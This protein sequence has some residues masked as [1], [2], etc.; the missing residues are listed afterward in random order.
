[1]T[2]PTKSQETVA[3]LKELLFAQ[4]SHEIDTLSARIAELQE[5]VG[6]DARFQQS[7]AEVLDG[8]L[9]DAE[10]ARHREL[11]DAMSPMVLRTLRTEMK[12]PDMQ[13]QITGLMY[14][15]MGELVRRYVASAV[16][17]M[18]QEINRRLEAGLS[19]NRLALWLR[20]LST[21]RPMAELA[22]A[23]TQ[24][25]QVEEL[26][27]IRRG[28]GELIQH[29]ERRGE[30]DTATEP[31]SGAASG[32]RDALVSGF[33][34]A[35][36]AFAEEAFEA[37]KETLRT[38][39]LDEHRLYIRG[40]P[41]HLLAAK[42]KGSAPAGVD[43]LFDGELIR[44]LGRHQ[45]IEQEARSLTGE[46]AVAHRDTAYQELLGDLARRLEESATERTRAMSKGHG[47]K[48]LW[49]LA[50]VVGLPLALLVGWQVH[51][52]WLT[53][54]LQ[55]RADSV[56]AG[57]PAL[58]GY[59]VKVHA[60]RGGGRLWV[61]GLVPDET[62]RRLVLAGLKQMAPTVELVAAVSV[63]PTT[64]VDARVGAAALERSVERVLP[65][66][67]ALATGL[68]AA[69][70]RLAEADDRAA[71][72]VAED[73][74]RGAA[75]QLT[76][77]QAESAVRHAPAGLAQSIDALQRSA[78]QLARLAG[79]EA[80]IGSPAPRDATNAIESLG[81][82][83]DRITGIVGQLEQRRRMAP[84]A[85]R[86]DDV[87][88]RIARRAEE[89]DQRAELRVTALERRLKERLAELESRLAALAPVPPTPREQLAAL[90]RANAVFFVN[91]TDYRDA[92]GT[93]ALI[94]SLVPLI[95]G[96]GSLVR[97]VG[98]TDETGT[99]ARN[100]A[101][102]QA[103]ADKVAADLVAQGA[104]RELLV[105][106]GRPGSVTLAPGTGPGSPNRRVEL[107]LGFQ[108]ERGGA[109]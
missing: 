48:A 77:L 46:A 44:V 69:R 22:L 91:D 11:A 30:G 37:G 74:A 35:I 104:P 95:K 34:T 27:L 18:M 10:A 78:D 107:E 40:A 12:S 67:S 89:V 94:A 102:A 79:A 51:V 20:S 54:R 4:E 64:D 100:L 58:A 108:G 42:C 98:Y 103:R 29:W 76:A 24:Q 62:S 70:D 49:A 99:S 7:V 83:A 13:D 55:E 88:E 82:L 101:L 6:S 5:R 47:H 90:T 68:L 25:L 87:G 15:R 26:F 43:Q 72:V 53:S 50:A 21:G 106:V 61:T 71:L 14:P 85:R 81:L 86:L 109:P 16:R 105:A 97:V 45:S 9:R 28:S 93:G 84:L 96:A 63:I 31:G 1:M 8:A 66:L 23:E 52:S 2:Q 73:A 92:A 38:L 57:V 33:L 80:V 17:D 75:Q 56:V 32:N 36:T 3:R 60:E 41:T 65:K 59:P 39:D 19:Q